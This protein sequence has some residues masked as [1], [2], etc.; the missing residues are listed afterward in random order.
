[1]PTQVGECERGTLGV[2][3]VA[4]ATQARWDHRGQISETSLQE[5]SLQVT[6]A[7][8]YRL[9]RQW[10][11]GTSAPLRVNHL[12]AGGAQVW[13]VGPGD[14][15]VSALWD[16]IEE[17][18]R[19]VPLLKL[20]VRIPTGISPEQATG[21]LFQDVTGLT[22]PAAIVTA[23]M[24]RSLGRVP[25]NVGVSVEGSKRPAVS[26][27]GSVGWYIGNAWTVSAGVSHLRRWSPSKDSW[28]HTSTTDASVRVITGSPVAWRAWVQAGAGVPLS[29]VGHSA[30]LK[31]SAATGV[32]KVF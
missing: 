18:Q 27:T 32:V 30:P 8:A 14:T 7:G 17:G 3:V 22:G 11:V 5:R 20:A 6:L 23:S 31:V 4:D 1:M 15:T 25:W 28:G 10:Q 12:A 24:D 9:N 29:Q 16:P 13:G 19:A 26:A 21:E 2:G